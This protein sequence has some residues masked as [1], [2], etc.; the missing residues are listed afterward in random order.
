MNAHSS[1][2][3]ALGLAYGFLWAGGIASYSFMGGPPDHLAWTA[4]LYL[5]LA[6]ALVVAYTKRRWWP[7]LA[8]AAG[9]GF[10]SE[11]IG[12]AF[13]VPYGGY[14]Y[15]DVL[16]PKVL[17]V[18]LVL[19]TAWLV[20]V[21]YV[22]HG[23]TS[24]RASM[25]PK[26]LAAALGA[27]WMTAIDF[28]IDPLAAGPLGYWHWEAGGAWYGIPWS[29]FL[30]WYLTSLAIFLMLPRTWRP[31]AAVRVIGASV[32]IFF[33]V[34]AFALGFAPVGLVA[35]AL[36]APDVLMLARRRRA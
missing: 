10:A 3:L 25:L 8:L 26:P 28:V 27:A 7:W 35:A 1:I 36:L 18:P 4:P 17:G 20:L 14:Q 29:N 31:H 11:L 9:I 15:T 2:R 33:G 24:E 19:T 16:G 13:G 6:G 5:A 22:Q 34:I 23:L 21:A 32:I 30:G 12:V